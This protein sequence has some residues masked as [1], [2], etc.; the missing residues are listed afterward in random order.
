MSALGALARARAWANQAAARF[1][2]RTGSSVSSTRAPPREAASYW[3]LRHASR[4]AL[5]A[6]SNV[7]G[8]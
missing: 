7:Y 5:T 6:R 2:S 8:F 4:A 1:G 3:T